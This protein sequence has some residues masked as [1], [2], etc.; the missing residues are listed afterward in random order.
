MY[1]KQPV[2]SKT[3]FGNSNACLLAP[4]KC[5]G[6]PPLPLLSQPILKGRRPT[7]HHHPR[8]T[9]QAGLLHHPLPSHLWGLPPHWGFWTEVLLSLLV[10]LPTAC[11]SQKP[12]FAMLICHWLSWPS[13]IRRQT[14][15]M[16]N[17]ADFVYVCNPQNNNDKLCWVSSK[18]L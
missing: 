18:Y 12:L 13:F 4:D 8:L 7:S 16:G 2:H 5:F 17:F 11:V 6:C 1:F 9:A 3:S 14:S 15:R 10:L